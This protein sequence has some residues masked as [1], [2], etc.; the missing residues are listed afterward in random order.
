VTAF[1]HNNYSTRGDLARIITA[2]PPAP[3]PGPVVGAWPPG[4]DLGERWPSRLV[5][6]AAADCLSIWRTSQFD[7]TAF[8]FCEIGSG[9]YHCPRR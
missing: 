8:S 5:P 7:Y 1:F 6:T 3:V 9:A 2:D 4:P